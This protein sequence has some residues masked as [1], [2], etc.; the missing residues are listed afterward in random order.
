MSRYPTKEGIRRMRKCLLESQKLTTEIQ[1]LGPE[2]A[3]KTKRL[4]EAQE[5]L[6]ALRSQLFKEMENMDIGT[7]GNFG[8]QSRMFA[9]LTELIKP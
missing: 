9:A 8:Y 4:G 7:S 2:I 1:Q 3:R 6:N 5:E